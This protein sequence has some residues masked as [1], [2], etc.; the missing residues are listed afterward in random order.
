MSNIT[1]RDLELINQYSKKPLTEEDVYT[2][3]VCLCNN[4]IDKDFECFSEASI[5]RLRDLF[6]G[7][8]GFIGSNFP[9]LQ[10][11]RIYCCYTESNPSKKTS[12]GA[13]YMALHA[14]AYIIKTDATAPIIAEIESGT[15]KEVSIA[16]AVEE[17]ICSICGKNIKKHQCEHTKGEVYDGKLCY[18]ILH[19]PTDAYEWSFVE[20][21]T[22]G[23]VL[24]SVTP[25]D[26]MRLSQVQFANLPTAEEYRQRKQAAATPLKRWSD[27][28]FKCPKCDGGA[29]C[30]DNTVVL[31][32]NPPK[33]VYQCNKCGYV[34]YL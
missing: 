11:A 9:S 4:E 34:E 19:N 29:M 3:T 13:S 12:Y 18:G 5:H 15:K 14:K 10:T 16:C 22:N 21:I 26:V 23:T 31:T 30:R 8:P 28:V 2:F 6:V 25:K 27:P 1:K 24:T 33:H 17:L 32:S 7:K 20:E